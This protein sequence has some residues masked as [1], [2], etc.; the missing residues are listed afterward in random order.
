VAFV[1]KRE[2][3][4][5]NESSLKSFALENAPA[6]QHPRSIWF[7]DS[8]PLASTNKLDRNMLRKLATEKVRQG[9]AS[10]AMDDQNNKAN[11]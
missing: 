9:T 7:V 5:L 2:G 6:Y 4:A 3:S 10:T 11:R 8:L 1:V